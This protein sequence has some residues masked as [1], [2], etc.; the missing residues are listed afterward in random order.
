MILFSPEKNRSE[1]FN[2]CIL[3]PTYYSP[4]RHKSTAHFSSENS[5]FYTAMATYRSNA[6]PSN[7]IA[8]VPI[9]LV[10]FA[11]CGR[12]RYTVVIWQCVTVPLALLQAIRPYVGPISGGNA[13][14]SQCWHLYSAATLRCCVGLPMSINPVLASLQPVGKHSNLPST[15]V[16][17]EDILHHHWRKR[18]SDVMKT[19]SV[20]AFVSFS[21]EYIQH[22]SNSSLQCNAM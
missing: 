21:M 14:H 7:S 13:W 17:I 8:A 22:N 20:A 11:A 3:V 9:L 12:T 18:T 16:Y 15:S 2:F 1:S 19:V 5:G 4:P 6:A 10:L